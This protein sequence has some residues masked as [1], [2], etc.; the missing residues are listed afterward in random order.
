MLNLSSLLSIEV[1][2]GPPFLPGGRYGPLPWCFPRWSHDTPGHFIRP[3]FLNNDLLVLQTER[4][5]PSIPIISSKYL[6]F[7]PI[8]VKFR[9]M[10]EQ[11]LHKAEL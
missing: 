4:F 1:R 9:G 7:A 6:Y 2:S 10:D 11:L 5:Y 8:F 3:S